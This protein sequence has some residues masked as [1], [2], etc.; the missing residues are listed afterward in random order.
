MISCQ[1]DI[2]T[3]RLL[4]QGTEGVGFSCICP[5]SGVAAVCLFP[6]P[7]LVLVTI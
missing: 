6:V 7:L 2:L 1:V 5:L 4:S 3:G